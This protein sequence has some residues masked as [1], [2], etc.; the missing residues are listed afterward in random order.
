MD[1]T[2]DSWN[3]DAYLGFA[4]DRTRPALEL[5]SRIAISNPTSIVD[6]GCGAG[7]VTA[8][9][10][11]RWKDA[12]I[13]GVDNS[14][15]MLA[16]AKTEYPD[17]NI[18]WKLENIN[19]WVSDRRYGTFDIVFSNAALHWVGKHGDL[20]PQ[21]MSRVATGGVLAVQMPNNFSAPSHKLM[22]ETIAEGPWADELSSVVK[23]TP[24]AWPAAYKGWLHPFS[25]N[26]E[27]WET[28]YTQHF[29]GDDPVLKW[30][31]STWL[32]PIISTLKGVNRESF[33]AVYGRRLREAYPKGADGRTVYKMRR[34]FILAVK[35]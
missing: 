5:I 8:I 12:A 4:N 1:N 34:T 22:A 16:R 7:N 17:K 14:P 19:D 33:L 23:G 30:I 2:S 26:V 32:A 25:K 35:D 6:L 9:L 11:K 13:S 21:L 15:A 29:D 27:V 3:P 31:S 10:R 18:N 28:H 24:V 20:F